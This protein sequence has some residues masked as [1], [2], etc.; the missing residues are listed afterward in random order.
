M[1]GP[2]I[3]YWNISKELSK[4]FDVVLFT[5]NQCN[6]QS[7]L[8]IKQLS[9][10][11]LIKQMQNA[12]CIILQGTTLWVHN[13]LK[14]LGIPIVVDLYDPF[15]FENMELF[16][17]DPG[18][19]SLHRASLAVLMDQLLWGD[20]FICASEK[21]KDYWIGML[22]AI[23]RVNPIEYGI[24]KTL[25]HLIGVV[26]FGLLAERPNKNKTVLKGMY[27]GIL[28][29][30]KVILW[31]G[32]IWNWLDPLTAIKAM[33]IISRKR[34]DIKLYFMGIKH[35]NPSIVQMKMVNDAIELSNSLALT[36]KSVFF[37]EWV[38]YDDRH[39][40]LLESD[41]GL[42]LHFNH[43]E[44]R[45]SYRTRILDYIW[46]ELPIIATRGDVMSKIVEEFKLG[47]TVPPE[48]PE[49]LADAIE[50][51]LINK[52]YKNHFMEA[53]RCLTWEKAVEELIAFC[54]N[55]R[56]SEGKQEKVRI[57]GLVSN[58]Y[59]Y[60]FIKSIHTIKKGNI[61]FLIDK[62]KNRILVK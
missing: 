13:Y 45:F 23:N 28:S 42:S 9:K 58:K 43:L 1:A 54:K 27:P 15:V 25:N 21:Q 4:Y 6:F 33:E 36:G 47:K 30:D 46:C 12:S 3:R 22:A 56:I 7:K 38:D 5:P 31:G 17:K 53:A 57:K 39:N 44:T 60:Y 48:S 51:I 55:P 18:A 59:Y 40:Y 35:P 50:D 29:N 8:Y 41:I 49:E 61:L 32:G 19:K 14:K 11:E 52:T 20:Y 62:M 37:N 26:P 34:V 16:Y 10:H 2:G 24:D